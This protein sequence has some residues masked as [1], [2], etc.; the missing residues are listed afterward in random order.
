MYKIMW[1][2]THVTPTIQNEQLYE[3]YKV[4]YKEESNL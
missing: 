2:V 3:Q 1:D 4:Y